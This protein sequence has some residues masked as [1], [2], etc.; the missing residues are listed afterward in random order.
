MKGVGMKFT[1]KRSVKEVLLGI[2]LGVSALTTLWMTSQQ[3]LAFNIRGFNLTESTGFYYDA[4]EDGEKKTPAQEAVDFLETIGVKHVVLNPIAHIEHKGSTDIVNATTFDLTGSD[5]TDRYVRLIRYIHSKGMTAGLRPIILIKDKGKTGKDWHGNIGPRV[6]SPANEKRFLAGKLEKEEIEKGLQAGAQKWFAS[7]RTYLETYANIAQF[8]E[9]EE[10]TIAAELYS[11][12]VGIEDQYGTPAFGYPREFLGVVKDI[13]QV[14]GDK[15]RLMLDINYTDDS[16]Q[17]DGTGNSGGE[18]ERWRQ[19]LV[20]DKPKTEEAKKTKSGQAWEMLKELW[21][22]FD[23]IGID[24]YRSLVGKGETLP[25][26]YDG[27]LAKLQGRAAQFAADLNNKLQAIH[28]A[29]GEKKRKRIIFKE[30]G[31][32]SCENSYCDPYAYDDPN[33]KVSME[34]QALSYQAT[35]NAYAPA[36]KAWLEGIVFW[37]IDVNPNRSGL[38]D[39]G[40]SVRGKPKTEEIIR[41]GWEM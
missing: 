4:A 22:S 12:T 32:K 15:T 36:R 39:P 6:L 27:K 38:K 5:E 9:T 41:R 24:N 28:Y 7:L 23:A 34:D 14:V 8:S 37:D 20:V 3:A 11:M 33:K 18:L 35:F 17:G 2:A 1:R 29:V 16:A 31:F 21:L 10:F 26:D 13:R 19:R 30:T 25:A 40:F